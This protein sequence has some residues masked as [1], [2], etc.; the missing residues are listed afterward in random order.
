V[1]D[2]CTT[3]LTARPST[4]KQ[5]EA[6]HSTWEGALVPVV[7]AGIVSTLH[8]DRIA[9]GMNHVAVAGTPRSALNGAWGRPA[10]AG[11]G[12]GG[13][14]TGEGPSMRIMTWGKG[15]LGQLGTARPRWNSGARLWQQDLW[16]KVL[17]DHATPVVS[18]CL[19]N[20][21]GEWVAGWVGGCRYEAAG[22][23]QGVWWTMRGVG[24]LGIGPCKPIP[25]SSLLPQPPPLI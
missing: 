19:H 21:V 10:G 5:K 12:S 1:F 3:F 6:Y 15:Q 25:P 9:A 24:S 23:W 4:D 22:W 14:V 2:C 8:V 17:A 11:G 16:D 7:V 20:W 13:G 18:G